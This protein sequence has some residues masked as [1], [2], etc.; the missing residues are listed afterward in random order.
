MSRG[1]CLPLYGPASKDPGAFFGC[2]FKKK[3]KKT[4]QQR[5]LFDFQNIKLE[6]NIKYISCFSNYAHELISQDYLNK[7]P[8]V[9]DLRKQIYCLIILE[10]KGPKSSCQQDRE[11]CQ[12]VLLGLFL[13]SVVCW[14]ALVLLDS[15][16]HH[17]NLCHCHH[18]ALSLCVSQPITLC[19][20]T[21]LILTSRLHNCLLGIDS[22]WGQ[23]MGS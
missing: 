10:A 13:V 20:S 17:S 7:V 21:G 23:W 6:Q 18:M 5:I 9:G 15:Q 19:I 22:W 14:Q 1:W 12:G 16:L 8:Q 11:P 4:Q 3:K 2:L